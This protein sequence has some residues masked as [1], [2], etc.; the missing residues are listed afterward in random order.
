MLFVISKWN[1]GLSAASSMGFRFCIFPSCSM[2]WW[3]AVF[4]SSEWEL[5]LCSTPN[6]P[7]ANT[8]ERISRLV[9]SYVL[10]TK[11]HQRHGGPAEP[12]AS[13]EFQCWSW[14]NDLSDRS[15][16]AACVRV[17]PRPPASVPEK[18]SFEVNS[19]GDRTL[20]PVF[21]RSFCVRLHCRTG[22]M[23]F[24]WVTS[25]RWGSNGF[26]VMRVHAARGRG[27]RDCDWLK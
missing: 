20:N 6:V 1:H 21:C 14:L 18:D 23:S 17:A 13:S 8:D 22:G 4:Y 16:C 24:L 5:E 15:E 25:G 26:M 27:K 7:G 9:S 12:H 10:M 3:N 11:T 2:K 19:R